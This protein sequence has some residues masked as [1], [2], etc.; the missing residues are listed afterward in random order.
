MS[1]DRTQ[2]APSPKNRP[3]P[4]NRT[5]T[6]DKTPNRA[7]GGRART[8]ADVEERVHRMDTEL[9]MQPQGERRSAQSNSGGNDRELTLTTPPLQRSPYQNQ[10]P[11]PGEDTGTQR[12]RA[13]DK[14]EVQTRARRAGRPTGRPASS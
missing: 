1:L 4:Y 12:T 11:R 10:Q 7:G 14:P 6:W 2:A 8:Q 9:H 13:G 5:L 3:S